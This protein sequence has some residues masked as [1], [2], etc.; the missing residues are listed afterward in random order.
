MAS[1]GI[2][3]ITNK[4]NGKF[5]LGS[6]D[7]IE[8][9]FYRHIY[10][11]KNNKHSNRHLQRS[12]NKHGK[13]AFELSVVNQCS[14]SELLSE[15]QKELDKWV[16]A[17]NCYNQAKIAGHPVAPGEKRPPWV[18]EKIRAAQKGIP[19]W[20]EEQ[21]KQMSIDRLGFKHKKETIQKFKN[22]PKSCYTGILKAQQ[23]N[24]G[25]IYSEDHKKAISQGK[26]MA[27][28]KF[29]GEELQRI[30]NGVAASYA[31]GK[32]KK[33]K[34]PKE[35]YITIKNLYLSGD[36]NKRQLAFKY[37]ISPSSM[38]KL[39]QRVGVK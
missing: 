15:E 32:C 23:F 26:Q 5:Y 12:F 28:K 1:C 19:K 35:E 10:D 16:G 18:V 21:K 33:N 2:Y 37:G 29:S 20:T 14:I 36:I 39:L 6:S 34:V 8:R 4:L 11:L 22:R 3:R 31:S 38:Q 7:N 30:R 24:I 25:R 27:Q 13:L 9:R 17:E